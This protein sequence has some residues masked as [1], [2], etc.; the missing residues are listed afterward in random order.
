MKVGFVRHLLAAAENSL[1]RIIIY[2]IQ[3]V[4]REKGAEVVFKSPQSR[5]LG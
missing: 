1:L 5:V 3:S 4:L 2:K